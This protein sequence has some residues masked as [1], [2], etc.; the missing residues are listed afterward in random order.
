MRR[1]TRRTK[2]TSERTV[3][4]NAR[5]IETFKIINCIKKEEEIVSGSLSGG[6][7]KFKVV[8]GTKVCFD[9]EKYAFRQEC[10]VDIESIAAGEERSKSC[11]RS[12]PQ[13]DGEGETLGGP[14]GD[15]GLFRWPRDPRVWSFGREYSRGP[16]G[17]RAPAS[18]SGRRPSWEAAGWR[19]I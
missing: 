8:N 13:Q 14:G 5:E 18:R 15:C 2:A 17:G 19:V 3:V 4:Q 10:D 12:P 1:R 7:A 9:H 6:E 16:A 11:L